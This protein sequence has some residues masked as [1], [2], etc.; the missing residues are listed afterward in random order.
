MPICI[1]KITMLDDYKTYLSLERKLAD[2]TVESY[3][4]DLKFF[5]QFLELKNYKVE[6]LNGEILSEFITYIS[7]TNISAKSMNRKIS[8]LKSFNKFLISER[9]LKADITSQIA[10]PKLGRVLP[11]YLTVDEVDQ[12]LS[13]EV[14][15]KND[16]RNKAIIEL[17]YS[18]G[19][20]VSEI[21]NLK[22]N[23]INTTHRSIRVRGKGN[24]DRIVMFGE[25]ALDSLRNYLTNCRELF[26]NGKPCE[27][28][29][30]N[31]HQKPIS[32]QSFWKIIKTI[33]KK[34]G[35]DHN[36]ISPHVLRHSF[37]THLVE[38][39]ANLRVVQ[40]LL[41]H[42]DISTTQK[43]THLN[44]RYLEESYN[45]IF[46]ELDLESEEDV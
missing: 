30:V 22:L 18:S 39:G 13:F 1:L 25:Y 27:Y 37:A 32:R 41:G 21:L 28:V 36:G 10:F 16:C 23:D 29:F 40:E 11:N 26:L 3:V 35:L 24:K 6:Q 46:N 33:A 44:T 7:M 43:Y 42:S 15:N 17:M 45:K 5:L 38:N 2:N 20:R 14:K 19:L 9:V 4:M 8:S 12:L 31:I 34:Q